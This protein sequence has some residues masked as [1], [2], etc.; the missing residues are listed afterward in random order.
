MPTIQTKAQSQNQRKNHSRHKKNRVIMK[1]DIPP[2]TRPIPI[3]SDTPT[4]SWVIVTPAV[5]TLWLEEHNTRNRTVRD[6]H[7]NNLAADMAAGKWNGRNGEPI[8]F[9]TDGNMFEGQHRCWACIQSN[10]PFETLLLTGCK[11]EDYQTSGTGKSK[12]FGDFLGP[13]HG[14]KNTTLLASATR[15]V[16]HWQN[17]T[18]GSGQVKSAG[19]TV[20]QM[21]ETYKA[22]PKL[23]ES[24]NRVSG[25]KKVRDLLTGTFAVL[26]HYAGTREGHQVQVENFLERLGDGLGLMEDSPIYQLR[27]FLLAQRAA[28]PGI[29]RPT[30]LYVL[31]LAIKAWNAEK[32]ERSVKVLQFR[33]DEAFPTL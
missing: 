11:P 12:H 27:K 29:R 8:K 2:D 32:A 22:H 21:T 15:L 7:V 19:L 5:A 18:M 28:R 9:D 20:T 33:A 26:L 24:V 6:D 4:A 16:W 25:M 13:V 30:R 1:H 31:A 14:E 17:G 23:A 10:T 3:K